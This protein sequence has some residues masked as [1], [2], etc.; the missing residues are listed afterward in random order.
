[1]RKAVKKHYHVYFTIK[2][3]QKGEISGYYSLRENVMEVAFD[4][5]VNT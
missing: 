1:L 5:G 3:R 4:K 2:E